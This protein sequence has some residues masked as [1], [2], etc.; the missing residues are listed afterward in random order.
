MN[1]KMIGSREM[2]I[3]PT[4]IFVLKRAPSCS[5]RRSTQRRRMVRARM[6]PKTRKAAVIKLETA[7]STITARQ[8]LGSNGTLSD[9]KVK[10]AASSNVRSIPPMARPQRCLL[11]NRL[12]ILTSS[13][14]VM[15]RVPGMESR[16]CRIHHG[17]FSSAA[18]AHEQNA[19]LLF[20]Q[21][22][23]WHDSQRTEAS[24]DFYPSSPRRTCPSGQVLAISER[25][26]EFW[27]P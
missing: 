15:K 3:A 14:H 24:Q 18:S 4:T 10:T 1:M 6:R 13:K 20:V 27:L 17:H 21:T 26:A 2:A 23:L 7:Y 19:S 25:R 12:M 9:P 16:E 5:R 11:S 22:S 8:L